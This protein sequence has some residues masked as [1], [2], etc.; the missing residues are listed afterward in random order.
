MIQKRK[1]LL[2]KVKVYTNIFSTEGVLVL[3]IPLKVAK[4][5]LL[6]FIRFIANTCVYF[7]ELIVQIYK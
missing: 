3:K 6:Q 5:N 7:K 4:L 2:V 1:G